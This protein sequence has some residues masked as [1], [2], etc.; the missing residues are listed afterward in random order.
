MTD[1]KKIFNFLKLDNIID[2]VSDLIEA[3]VAVYKVEMKYE[4]AK[5]GSR[6]LAFI[7]LSFI[8]FMVVLFLSF[9]GATLLNEVLSSR[10]WGYAI[11]TGFYL[12]I[13]IL[14][15]VLDVSEMFRKKFESFLLDEADIISKGEKS[16]TKETEDVE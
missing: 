11:I 15:I 8:L 10:F 3:K 16:T 9:T 5:I 12:L 13:F 1:Y 14:F 2:H 7:I 6:L 4:V